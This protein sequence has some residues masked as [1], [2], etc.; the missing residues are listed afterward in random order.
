MPAPRGRTNQKVLESGTYKC[1]DTGETWSYV[2]GDHFR[3]CPSTGAPTL[4]IK[5][6]EPPD[7]DDPQR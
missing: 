4:W 5:T 7:P 3:P 6:E 2:Q 1:T